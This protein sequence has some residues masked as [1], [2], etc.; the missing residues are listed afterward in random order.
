MAPQAKPVIDEEAC[1]GCGT[2]V[3][4]CPEG[5]LELVGDKAKLAYPR[6]VHRVRHLRGRV[7]RWGHNPRGVRGGWP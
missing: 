4:V 1:T 5:A 6:Q 2:C 3:D 7:P